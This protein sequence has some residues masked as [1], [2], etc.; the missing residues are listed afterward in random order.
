MKKVAVIVG[1]KSDTEQIQPALDLLA[2]FGVPVEF[3][4]LSAHRD[5]DALR[6]YVLSMDNA[7]YAAI[8]AAAGMAAALPG[9]VAAHTLLPVIGVPMKGGALNG[10]DA[11]YSIVQMPK[12]VPVGCM[13][14]GSSGSI[15]AALLAIRIMALTDEGLK[16]KLAAY[17]ESQK[18]A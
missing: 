9:V 17:R 12:G 2:D 3:K 16:E 13:A 10:V 6:E 14:I 18:T 15:N 5:T 11:L 1:S 4:V 7:G 8:I